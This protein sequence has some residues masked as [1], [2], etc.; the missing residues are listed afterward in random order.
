MNRT[1]FCSLAINLVGLP[2]VWG[3]RDP[4]YAVD[5]WGLVSATFLAAGEIVVAKKFAPWWTEKAWK[6][7]PR[8]KTDEEMLPGDLI[9]YGH[10][11][12]KPGDEVDHVAIH[13]GHGMVLTASGGGPTVKSVEEAKKRGALVRAYSH[14]LYNPRLVG[15]S[16]LGGYLM[17]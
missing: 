13:L 7:L 2:Y 8:L 16:S 17:R 9:F 1:R 15:F 12:T 10:G 11:P 5:C 14:Y 4:D 6:E 3:A